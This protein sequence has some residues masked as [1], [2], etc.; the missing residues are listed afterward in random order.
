MHK[1]SRLFLFIVKS[2]ASDSDEKCLREVDI[3]KFGM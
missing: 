2:L 3:D 1:H